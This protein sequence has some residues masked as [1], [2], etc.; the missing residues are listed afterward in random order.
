MPFQFGIPPHNDKAHVS[1]AKRASPGGVAG[2]Y[3]CETLLHKNRN[4]IM[5]SYAASQVTASAGFTSV[6]SGAGGYM[7]SSSPYSMYVYAG[8][9]P[10]DNARVVIPY[11]FKIG[12]NFMDESIV[13]QGFDEGIGDGCLLFAGFAQSGV[14]IDVWANQN[15]IGWFCE[16]DGE[17]FHGVFN[18]VSGQWGSPTVDLG[19]QV[20]AGDMLTTRLY[21]K[22]GISNIDSW[23]FY[24]NGLRVAYAE[25]DTAN[26]PMVNM[27]PIFGAYA[28]SAY[29][30]PT[31]YP[32]MQV[33]HINFD[34]CP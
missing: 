17:W 34:Y 16:D 15:L 29:A 22:E 23:A 13:L 21:R 10:G 9:T 28:R 24:V 4:P 6:S 19:R 26:M 32:A 8:V 2:L 25:S 12:G 31:A 7:N 30:A 3:S 5:E 18:A 33:R 11:R 27:Y 1:D 20:Q 14:D